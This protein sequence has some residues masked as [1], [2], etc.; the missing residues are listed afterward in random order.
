MPRGRLL[1]GMGPEL[2][3]IGGRTIRPGA[4]ASQVRSRHTG[5]SVAKKVLDKATVVNHRMMHLVPLLNKPCLE[6]I[7][8]EEEPGA[9]EFLQIKTSDGLYAYSWKN[10]TSKKDAFQDGRICQ[11][12]TFWIQKFS[13]V[14]KVLS[15][16]C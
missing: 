16:A 13:L 2:G 15:C 1:R 6:S 12:A 5:A 9:N 8:P 11:E 4:L 10:Y 7:T 3:K 14:S